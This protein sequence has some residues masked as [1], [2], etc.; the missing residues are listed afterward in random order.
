MR[1]LPVVFASMI[2]A[3]GVLPLE[4]QESPDPAPPSPDVPVVARSA[5][6]AAAGWCAVRDG[7]RGDGEPGCDAGIAGALKRW[8]RAS[9]VVALGGETVGL[10]GSWTL[11]RSDLGTA[12]AVAAGVIAPYDGDGVD[13]SG[14]SP[15]VGATLSF[16]RGLSE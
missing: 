6:I 11:W 9:L 10:G 3:A 13:L 7:E 16:G 4:G 2:L 8:E 5:P 15:A 14:W 12:F 1:R